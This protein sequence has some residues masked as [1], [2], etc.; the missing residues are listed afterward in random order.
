MRVISKR[1]LREFWRMPGHEDAENALKTWFDVT[2]S[3]R[4]R[5]F[6]DVKQDYGKRVDM[7]HGKTIFDIG[8]NKYRLIC[9]ID[10]QGQGVLVLWVGTHKCYDALNAND[11][12]GMKDL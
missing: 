1:R 3:A 6:D 8:G 12:R 7:A 4:W 5:H 9:K 11:G 10:Y 2:S